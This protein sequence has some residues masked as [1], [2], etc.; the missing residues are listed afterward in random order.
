MRVTY[1]ISILGVRM[2]EDRIQR[3]IVTRG[4]RV[5][6]EYVAMRPVPF[7]TAVT[8]SAVY[9][10]ATVATTYV[11]GRVIDEVV[12]PAFERGPDRRALGA[13]VA[14]ILA[15]ALVRIAG[16]LTRRYFAG[17]TTAQIGAALRTRLADRYR[18][19]PLSFHQARSTG[20]LIAHAEADVRAATDILHP[21]PFGVA[22]LVL[23][24]AASVTLVAT[25]LVL[26]AIG[27]LVLPLL[28][29]ANH[30]YTRR[31]EDPATRVQE[32]IGT[33]STVAHESIDGALVVKTL[34]RE[35]AEVNRLA[36]EA[37]ALRDERVI[38]G[39][40][41]ASF[42]PSFNALPVLGTIA[43]IA[44]GAWRVSTGAITVGTLV[45]FVSLFQVIVFPAQVIGFVLS[46][47]PRAVVSRERLGR[48]FAA[49]I[50]MPQA[51]ERLALPPGPL[52]LSVRAVTFA[53]PSQDDSDGASSALA[54]IAKSG[55]EAGASGNAAA[56]DGSADGSA[57]AST[58]AST[59]ASGD[60]AAGGGNGHNV[61]DGVSFEVAPG[62]TVAL[63]G[64]TGAGK[65]TLA[66][67]LVR[68]SDP[69]YGSVRLGGRDLRHLDPAELRGAAALA[70]QEGF[71]FAASV[72]E[73]ITLGVPYSEREVRWALRVAQA[74]RFV[75]ALPQGL[76]TVLGERGVTLSGGQ[77]QRVALARALIRRPRLLIL[78]DATSAVDPT[79]EAQILAGLARELDATVVLV[80]YRTSTIRLASRVLFLNG[81]RIEAT[82]THEDLLARHPAYE[83]MVRAYERRAA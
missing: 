61:L 10:L 70:F 21:T 42:Y 6:A 17:L 59:G 31:A 19:V 15:V 45:Q 27:A 22:V 3:G 28:V 38:V 62:E 14:A 29:W 41:R 34:G 13:G 7:V 64:P 8:G 37:E 53:Y 32:R 33:V 39:R 48:V 80:A 83:A 20:E 75:H 23:L 77:R 49:T 52:G 76:D 63:V 16:I 25:D 65:S 58:G 1:P 40:L 81:G 36:R 4:V 74:D 5:L 26:S 12:L 11:L 69:T 50:G 35:R 82:G 68:L 47:V 67:L 60:G 57:S 66:E 79:I 44:V 24:T 71:L 56:T 2:S 30:E 43:L 78:D 55:S 46:E 18:E 54:S 73:N 9:A 51:G 72:R